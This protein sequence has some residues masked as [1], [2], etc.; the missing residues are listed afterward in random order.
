[1]FAREAEGAAGRLA[2]L[3]KESARLASEI[4]RAKAHRERSLQRERIERNVVELTSREGEMNE[5]QR[6]VELSRA[7]RP[8]ALALA[9][10]EALRAKLDKSRAEADEAEKG[11]ELAKAESDRLDGERAAMEGLA[12]EREALLVRKERLELAVKIAVDLSADREQAERAR[13]RKKELVASAGEREKALSRL[14]AEAEA[15]SLETSLLEGRMEEAS[16]AREEL[17]RARALK[18]L[19]DEYAKESRALAGHRGALE[20]F[21]KNV[22]DAMR[23]IEIREAEI[24]DL[25]AEAEL[26]RAAETALSLA[27]RLRPGQPC[28]VCGSNEHPAPA[29]SP[30]SAKFD[31]EDRIASAKRSLSDARNRHA[32]LLAE[33]AGRAANLETAKERARL[34]REAFCSAA[35]LA[36]SCMAEAEVP[37]PE[38]GA[39]RLKEASRRMQEASDAATRTQKALRE[40]E[41]LRKAK[42]RHERDLAKDGKSSRH[43]KPWKP[44]SRPRYATKRLVISRP[45]EKSRAKGRSGTAAIDPSEAAE[46]IEIVNSRSLEI[47][48]TRSS[49][50]AKREETMR[51]LSSL[52]GARAALAASIAQTAAELERA[53][54]AYARARETAGFADDAAVKGATMDDARAE[55]EVNAIAEW[56]RELDTARGTLAEVSADVDSWKGPDLSELERSLAANDEER[57]TAEKARETALA[58]ASR[59]DSL[60]AQHDGLEAERAERAARAGALGALAGD[61]TGANPSRVSFDAWILGMYLEEITKFANERLWRMSEGR[62]RIKLNDSYRKGNNLSGL[63]LEIL[64]S[65]TGKS[66]PSGTLS[67]GETFM[68]SISLALGLADSIQSRTGG[69]QLD[70][71]FIDEGFGSLDEASLERALSILDEIR[72]QRMVGI[73]SHV[74]ELKNRIPNRIEVVKQSAGSIIRKETLHA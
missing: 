5:R 59:L 64:D 72:G 6:T 57:E 34:H 32:T 15:L 21:E 28:P 54:S 27:A 61:L 48:A 50:E 3:R 65:Y 4:E 49:H 18:T 42:D 7:A 62:Y 45:S 55:A 71:V 14:T 26:E 37:S 60:K 9:S 58:E 44:P 35:G 17:E 41:E 43:W 20:A 36:P 46:E 69:I 22:S 1:V 67:G 38:E 52:E 30:A 12:R 2:S 23:D 74:P 51:S 66:R 13:A 70:A 40:L 68:T 8:L 39:E 53:E 47:E 11:L 33:A 16:K 10:S 29:R 63:D 31:A 73:I 56:K 19:C 24:N 25:M